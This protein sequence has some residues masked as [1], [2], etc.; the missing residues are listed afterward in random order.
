MI[1]IE[2]THAYEVT[3]VAQQL[4]SISAS[5]FPGP[6]HRRYLGAGTNQRA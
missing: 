4:L 6:P 3:E 2:P 5:W 1:R